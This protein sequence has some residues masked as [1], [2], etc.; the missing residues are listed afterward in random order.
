MNIKDRAKKVVSVKEFKNAGKPLNIKEIDL[1]IPNEE[2]YILR[3]VV[4]VNGQ[5]FYIPKELDWIKPLFNEALKHQREVIQVT[6]SFCYIT[7]RHGLVKSKTDEE[8]HVDGFSTKIT[9]IPEQNYTWCNKIG[10]EYSDLNIEFPNDFDPNKFNVNLFLEKHINKNNIHKCKEKT[11]YCFDPYIVHRRPIESENT[12]R[13]FVRISFVPIE[14]NDINN[15]QN[16]LLQRLYTEDGV[17]KRNTLIK[18]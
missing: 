7:I 10:T 12:I 13:T 1:E 5:D 18:Y 9:H 11:L 6:H 8:W 14:I 2:Q 4:S 15:T 17:A 16:K 3:M